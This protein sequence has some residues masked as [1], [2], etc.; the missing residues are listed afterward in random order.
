MKNLCAI[1]S[2]F[3]KNN[4]ISGLHSF[5]SIEDAKYKNTFTPLSLLNPGE[6]KNEMI[7]ELKVLNFYPKKNIAA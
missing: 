4:L 5:M 6:R 2:I 7:S 3:D 1:R